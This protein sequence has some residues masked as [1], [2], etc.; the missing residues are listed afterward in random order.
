[1]NWPVWIFVTA[2]FSTVFCTAVNCYTYRLA[3][4][5]WRWVGRNEYGALHKEYLR[6]LG[7]VITAPHVVMFFASAGLLWKRPAF[8]RFGDA[9]ALFVLN[10]TVVG[11]S[12]ALAGPTHSRFERSGRL[13]DAGLVLLLQ[14]SALRS[15]L[16]LVASSM[17]ALRLGAALST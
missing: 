2:L 11:V 10:A 17:L 8:F 12:A 3:Y 4:P 5:L 9:L 6:R 15:I 13:D 14:I 1:M 16:M 7:P